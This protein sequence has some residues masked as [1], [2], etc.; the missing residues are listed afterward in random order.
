IKEAQ[1]AALFYPHAV[2]GHPAH[3]ATHRLLNE[4]LTHLPTRPPCF[5]TEY[6]Q[7][8][9]APNLLVESSTE[10]VERL[11]AAL[12]QHTGEVQRNP[13]HRRLPAWLIDNVR[14]GA[15][16]LGG[17]GA[18][19]LPDLTFG[20]LYRALDSQGQP[21]PPRTLRQSDNLIL[22]PPPQSQEASPEPGTCKT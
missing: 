5:E 17:T 18:D 1:P 21:R 9:R 2:D 15:E 14:R 6:W 16:L 3:I 10:Q 8:M 22:Q 12:A 13:Y 19:G 7:A 4:A 11:V 20:T